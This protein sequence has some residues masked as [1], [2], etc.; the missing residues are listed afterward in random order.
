MAEFQIGN[1]TYLFTTGDKSDRTALGLFVKAQNHA[2]R[3][4]QPQHSASLEDD[5]LRLKLA[6]I[7]SGYKHEIR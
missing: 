5:R 2:R 6:L 7:L 1:D 3:H 4:E